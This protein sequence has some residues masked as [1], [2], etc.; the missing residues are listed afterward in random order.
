MKDVALMI[1]VVRAEAV[2]TDVVM[3]YVAVTGV[4]M[5]DVEMIDDVLSRQA[6]MG[7]SAMMQSL[8]SVRRPSRSL[9]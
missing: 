4:V 6:A 8:D 5:I 1:G 7:G 3:A 9:A 2:M